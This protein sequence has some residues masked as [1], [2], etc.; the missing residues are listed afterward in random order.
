[1]PL[2][3]KK[4]LVWCAFSAYRIFGPYIFSATVKQD[5]YL[6]ILQ[7]FFWPALTKT[8]EYKKSFFQQDGAP[9]HRADIVQDWLRAKFGTQWVSKEFW[10]PRSPDLNPC[11]SFL[12]GYLKARVYNPLPTNLEE[13]QENIER[14]I[15][16]IPKTM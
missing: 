2:Q 11:D 16:N 6:D 1:M 5:N 12:W 15:H 9:V 13:L 10:P 14:K 3:N 8:R 4:L 7:N